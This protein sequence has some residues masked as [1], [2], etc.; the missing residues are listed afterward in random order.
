VPRAAGVHS[1]GGAL[2][3]DSRSWRAVLD[4]DLA[5]RLPAGHRRRRRRPG[6][7]DGR[8]RRVPGTHRQPRQPR[9]HDNRLAALQGHLRRPRPQAHELPALHRLHS[10]R[11]RRAAHAD[12][13]HAGRS[14]QAGGSDHAPGRH[15]P[16]H[17][18]PAGASDAHLP[19]GRAPAAQRPQRR[20]LYG[21]RATPAQLAAV[22]VVHVRRGGKILVSATRRS[23]SPDVGAVVQVQAECAK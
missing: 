19:R 11:R 20:A 17:S 1:R 18:G 8:R 13:V 21:R 22:R 4:C 15:T 7:R 12:G 2:G 3:R 9:H 16:P 5:A 10:R 23:L 6:Q 14:R